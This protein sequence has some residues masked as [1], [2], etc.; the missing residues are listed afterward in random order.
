[1]AIKKYSGQ[2]GFEEEMFLNLGLSS[3]HSV[4]LAQAGNF[5]LAASSWKTYKT[6]ENHLKACMEDV[7]RNMRFPFSVGDVLTFIAWLIAKRGVRAKT[8]MIYLSGLRMVHFQRGHFN[9]NLHSD[10]VKHIL[11]GLK[12]KDIIKD[13]ISGNV[14]RL[15]VTMEIMQMIKEELLKCRWDLRKKRL[16][17][18][19]AALAFSG[20]FRVHEL[21]SRQAQYYDPTSTLLVKDITCQIVPEQ[22]GA[23]VLQV[24]LKS[25]KE[26]RLKLGIQ[27]DLFSTG[28]YICPVDAYLKY[29]RSLVGSQELSS[30]AFITCAK[31]GYTGA[32]FNKDIKKLLESKIDYARAKVTSHSFRAG[33]AT[34]MGKLGYKDEEIQSIGR[35]NSQAYLTYVKCARLKRMTIAQELSASILAGKRVNR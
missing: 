4:V 35:W 13:K 26:R 7:G 5:G 33:L 34:E 20:S 9:I 28:S 16:V 17:W 6:A 23:K 27:V 21:L 12:Q 8:I 30:P 2:G 32:D 1:M 14:E 3:E 25:P 15:P 29:K 11:T 22:G 18:A 24:F 31:R 19:V 10:I